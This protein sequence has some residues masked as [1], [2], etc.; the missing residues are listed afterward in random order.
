MSASVNAECD[1]GYH[2]C[3]VFL[4]LTTD[5]KLPESAVSLQWS[6]AILKV[7]SSGLHL[8]P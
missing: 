4:R 7:R 2:R 6:V 5:P 8:A 3:W 1:G